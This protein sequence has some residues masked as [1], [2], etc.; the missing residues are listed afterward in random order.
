M[1]GG[2]KEQGKST[3]RRFKKC[4]RHC[5]RYSRGNRG[6]PLSGF[7]LGEARREFLGGKPRRKFQTPF[8]PFLFPIPPVLSAAARQGR[9]SV[10]LVLGRTR[11]GVAEVN[12]DRNEIVSSAK[13]KGGVEG[14]PFSPPLL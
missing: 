1:G 8:P 7:R 14:N 13:Q 9:G 11:R 2:G 6:A 4:R 5:Y 3:K 10:S 12:P